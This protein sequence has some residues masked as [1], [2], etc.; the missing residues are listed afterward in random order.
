MGDVNVNGW[1]WVCVVC[2]LVKRVWESIET[3]DLPPHVFKIRRWT[4]GAPRERLA[5]CRCPFRRSQSVH[6]QFFTLY[7]DSV[8]SRCSVILFFFFLYTMATLIQTSPGIDSVSNEWAL[9]WPL[10]HRQRR[11]WANRHLHWNEM[12]LTFEWFNKIIM[13]CVR[14]PECGVGFSEMCRAPLSYTVTITLLD[15]FCPKYPK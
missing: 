14:L 9:L 2:D 1:V 13:E 3:H 5:L 10:A 8:Q 11:L 15:N 12:P 4:V 7:W 6:Q